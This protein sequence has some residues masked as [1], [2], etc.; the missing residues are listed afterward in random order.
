MALSLELQRLYSSAPDNTIIMDAV[1]LSC[2]AWSETIYAITKVIQDTIKEFPAGTP[3]TFMPAKFALVRPKESDSGVVEI[4]ID[5]E[6]TAA[7]YS[8]L[9]EA[10]RIQANITATFLV[11][12]EK[13]A[14][15]A[16]PPLELTL[17][18]VTI[19]E[20]TVSFTARNSGLVDKAFPYRIALADSYP[21]LSR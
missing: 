11:Y 6:T 10:E 9:E 16:A 12:T 2:L 17:D 19:T 13:D 15:P 4:S 18:S 21:G 8:L 20:T 7:L 3:Q 5:F 1:V 14:A